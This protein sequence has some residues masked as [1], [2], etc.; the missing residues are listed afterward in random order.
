M[1]FYV[2]QDAVNKSTEGFRNKKAQVYVVGAMNFAAICLFLHERINM[3]IIACSPK[4]PSPVRVVT[5]S[6]VLR[7]GLPVPLVGCESLEY[8]PVEEGREIVCSRSACRRRESWLL[9]PQAGRLLKFANIFRIVKGGEKSGCQDPP[10]A[11]TFWSK[12]K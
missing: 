4:L 10:P 1:R 5:G 9:Q 3:R 8:C 11:V 6:A 12:G 2:S 7:A